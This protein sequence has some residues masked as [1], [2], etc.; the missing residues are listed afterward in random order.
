MLERM[1]TFFQR[2]H[3][4]NI[5]INPD[6]CK[7]GL[8]EVEYVGHTLSEKYKG[9]T[10]KKRNGIREFPL[11]ATPKDLR[12]FLGLAN[13]FCDHVRNMSS[14]TRKL[15]DMMGDGPKSRKL[16]WTPALVQHF[17][18]LKVAIADCPNLYF[19]DYESGSPVHLYTDASDYGIGGYLCQLI[20][21]KQ[22]PIHFLSKSFDKV[23]LRWSTP[24]K[25][26]YAI[27]Y[28]LTKMQ[29]LLRDIH[30]TL[31][32]DHKNL[33][34]TYSSGS[35]KVLRW[36]LAIQE[37]DFDI[38]HV[39]GEQNIAADAFSR[40]CPVDCV[41]TIQVYIEDCKDGMHDFPDA[42]CVYCPQ[43]FSAY[44][45]TIHERT[46]VDEEYFKT[47]GTVHNDVAGHHGVERT[48]GKLIRQGSRWLH[49]REHIRNFVKKCPKCQKNSQIKLA[50]HTIPFVT[51]TLQPWECINVDTIGPLPADSMGYQHII[52]IIDTF[53]RFVEL[54]AVTDT[55]GETA[56]RVLLQHVGRFGCPS[57]IRTD[58][59]PEYDN[60]WVTELVRVIG[61]EHAKTLAYS[62][63]ENAIVERSNKE[64]MRHLRA[65]VFHT[66]DK[67]SLYLPLVQ[68]IMNATVHGSTGVRPA[69]LIFGRSVDLDRGIFL[70]LEHRSNG[71]MALSA[72]AD[73][74]LAMQ[75]L[76]MA[77]ATLSQSE[78]NELHLTADRPTPTQFP[79]DSLVLCNYHGN[80]LGIRTAPSKL[81]SALKGP[82]RV[83]KRELST[84]TLLNLATNKL[85]EHH[86]TDLRPFVSDGTSNPVE[87]ARADRQ[88]RIVSQI[89]SHRGD[90]QKKTAMEF[91]IRWE[92]YDSAHDSWEVWSKDL[93]KLK[94]FHEYL[95]QHGLKKLVPTEFK[96]QYPAAFPRSVLSVPTADT[97]ASL[98]IAAEALLPESVK[99]AVAAPVVAVP[100]PSPPLREP[101]LR[102]DTSVAASR[103]STR[104]IKRRVHF[105]D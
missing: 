104:P 89:L 29:H 39:P 5:T 55:K 23:Q 31:F 71:Q 70:P 30:F 49:M 17:E 12:S 96:P 88:T 35:P 20:S 93:R 75:D 26:A 64:V 18:S 53:S 102:Q 16:V 54:Y 62:K 43:P 11:P 25:E 72:W 57:R 42:I 103:I 33:T 94:V 98:D 73:K 27:Y 1:E 19:I 87:V 34:Y 101:I 48:L 3:E 63:E 8:D 9:F 67:W 69:D 38:V 6:K 41:E 65:L 24:E 40:L 80:R 84:Y 46:H 37:F 32:T 86:V 79:V 76:L 99:T 22:Y 15:R 74:M 51:S 59:G 45:H 14:L 82:L 44:C 2:C 85:E 56:V 100:L 50:I 60:R 10:D 61:T 58:N 13:Y 66:H 92:G 105:G 52:V 28:S 78:K 90:P 36:K 47:I 97:T 77:D 83:V 95:I 7:L 81:H 4:F 21:D 91:Y 68:R